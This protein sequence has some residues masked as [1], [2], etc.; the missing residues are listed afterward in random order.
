MTTGTYEAKGTGTGGSSIPNPAKRSSTLTELTL[1]DNVQVPLALADEESPLELVE[2]APNPVRFAG[3][4][5]VLEAF[6]ANRAARADGLGLQFA[7]EPLVL[8]LDVAGGEEQ[9]GVFTAAGGPP[10]PAVLPTLDRLDARPSPA[11]PL[12]SCALPSISCGDA[13]GMPAVPPQTPIHTIDTIPS[14]PGGGL[15]DLNRGRAS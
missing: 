6:D 9:V 11:D 13:T 12:L 5:G 8:V 2:T 10:L 14:R 4:N 7:N 15:G 1:P 3:P